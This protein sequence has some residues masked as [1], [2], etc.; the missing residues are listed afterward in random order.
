MKL[1]TGDYKAYKDKNLNTKNLK[2]MREIY[3]VTQD[4]LAEIAKVSRVSVS[5]WET[6][7]GSKISRINL[8]KL[9]NLY[10]LGIEYFFG[11]EIDTTA[12]DIIVS[13][14]TAS[15]TPDP[16]PTPPTPTPTPQPVVPELP[17]YYSPPIDNSMTAGQKDEKFQAL[18]KRYKFQDAMENYFCALK[19]VIAL[20]ME[21]SAEELDI[22]EAIEK[23][24]SR[25]VRCAFAERRADL[26][27]GN[28]IQVL[29]SQLEINK[30]TRLF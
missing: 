18:F 17:P 19:L 16:T 1:L 8:E 28:T 26:E 24:L 2:R 6:G 4:E 5:N 27:D 12:R 23:Q 22:A 9:M 13:S 15:L 29:Y 14:R 25:R 21:C 11:R 3:G 10:G 30:E 20:S 7:T